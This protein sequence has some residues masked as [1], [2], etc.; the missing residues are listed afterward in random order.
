[1]D[2]PYFHAA[3]SIIVKNTLIFLSFLFLTGNA[4][5]AAKR[6]AQ[7][8]VPTTRTWSNSVFRS[9]LAESR[10]DADKDAIVDEFFKRYEDEV[11]A[12]PEDHGM[13]YVH[14][15]IHIQKTA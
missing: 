7:W 10:P 15:Y 3:D 9:A 4:E 6:H 11:A 2:P 5:A 12:A 13:D 14:A 8:Y 1:M